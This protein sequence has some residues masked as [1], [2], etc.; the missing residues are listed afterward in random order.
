MIVYV[1]SNFVLELALEQE[2]WAAANAILALAEQRKIK[3]AFP[4]FVL[5][6]PFEQIARE[7]RERN[8]LYNSLLKSLAYLQRSEPHRNILFT[9]EPVVKVLKEAP[10]RQFE[11]LHIIFEKLLGV[12]ECVDVNTAC[13]RNALNYQQ[14]LGLSPQE[15]I[16]Y[17]AMIGNL[18]ARSNDEVK[19]FLRRDRKAFDGEDNRPIKVELATYNC[20]YIGSFQQGLDYIEHALQSAG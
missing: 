19:S 8:S 20:R 14:R 9:M 4:G 12:G 6:E 10:F 5:S 7:R 1:E 16:I 11:R 18:K 3:L 15:S 2:Q 13:F 17:A